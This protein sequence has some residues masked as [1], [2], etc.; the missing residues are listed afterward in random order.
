MVG[1]KTLPV[2]HLVG[3]IGQAQDREDALAELAERFDLEVGEAEQVFETSFS[4][5]V[6]L[7]LR[8]N[9][10]QPAGSD[11][12]EQFK[13]AGGRTVYGGGGITPD[14]K[15]EQQQRP[16]LVIAIARAGLFFDF[17][18]Q[19]AATYSFPERP[20]AFAVDDEVIQAFRDFLADSSSTGGF[21]HRTP[22]ETHLNALRESLEEADG[23][24]AAREWHE[25]L[26]QIVEREREAEFQKADPY[27]RL[28]IGREIGNRVWGA[29]GLLLATLKGDK[30]YQ[31]AVRILRDPDLYQEK[32]KVAL[33]SGSP[34]VVGG[35]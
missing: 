25:P 18:V 27:L 23:P 21:E 19:Y 11:P 14:V 6:G 32:M 20:D 9:D 22:T 2:H 4:Q 30:Q 17:A 12:V 33:A 16:R 1:A 10:N 5:I 34:A 7:G 8:M 28:E 35:R 31:E 3:M 26:G 15:V 13:T 24:E 29:R